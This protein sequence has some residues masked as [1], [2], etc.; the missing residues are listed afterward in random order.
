MTQPNKLDHAVSEIYE[1]AL[2]PEKWDS[3]LVAIA[4][5]M[6][7]SHSAMMIL[8][9]GH[10]VDGSM[11]MMDPAHLK[12]YANIKANEPTGEFG[13]PPETVSLGKVVGIDSERDRESFEAS[14]EYREWWTEHDLGIGALFANL[15]IGGSRLAQIG[16][17][18][19]RDAGFTLT[20]RER[21]ENLCDHLLRASRIEK[22]LS[23]NLSQTSGS[24]SHGFTT[25]LIVDQDYQILTDANPTLDYLR[26]LGLIE[27]SRFGEKLALRHN[28]LKNLI[29]KAQPPAQSGGSFAIS[30]TDGQRVWIDVTP[31]SPKGS[32]TDWL[33][34]DR[35]AALVQVTLPKKRIPLRVH[36]LAREFG[37]TP[38]ER[39]V[40]VEI[41]K[42]DGRAATARRLGV[43]DSTVRS[44]LSVIFQ[45]TGV[46]RQAELIELL[47]G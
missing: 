36:G 24:D 42:G 1:A 40:A 23:S 18:R 4:E 8:E 43:S 27:A 33:C 21:L 45:K 14:V 22:R 30:S 28:E 41:I 47:V 26:E 20:D 17:Y 31:A 10:L 6:G 13:I 35:P 16:I 3:A 25:N 11:P 7:A 9:N 19:P 2:S 32:E 12:T 38:A 46:H 5:A 34:L 44:H 39:A 29:D 37:L 15:A